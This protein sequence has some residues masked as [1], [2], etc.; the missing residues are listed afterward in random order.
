MRATRAI[1]DPVLPQSLRMVEYLS[2]HPNAK[3]D[4]LQNDLAKHF[5]NASYVHHV[6]SFV[7]NKVGTEVL[8][9][10]YDRVRHAWTYSLAMSAQESFEYVRGR[11]VKVRNEAGNLVQIL[12]RCEAKWPADSDLRLCRKML[13]SVVN[14]L[15]E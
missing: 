12:N 11:R 1:K 3:A 2:K 7:R 10:S 9:C 6:I 4:E 15:S 13:E 8:V 14:I 5:A